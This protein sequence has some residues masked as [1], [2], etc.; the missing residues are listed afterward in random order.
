MHSAAVSFESFTM[1]KRFRLHAFS[2]V[3]FCDSEAVFPDHIVSFRLSP[4]LSCVQ[5]SYQFKYQVQKS[6]RLCF[7]DSEIDFVFVSLL[8]LLRFYLSNWMVSKCLMRFSDDCESNRIESNRISILST[9][10]A[11]FFRASTI[12]SNC[13]F[14]IFT[15][16]YGLL[17]Q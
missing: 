11:S 2:R 1:K 7:D 5:C 9:I 14:D 13:C 16:S 3:S 6:S 10:H 12:C 17:A 4:I 15:F 8:L